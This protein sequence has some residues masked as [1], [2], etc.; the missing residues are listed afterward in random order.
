MIYYVLKP[1]IYFIVKIF[2][3]PSIKGLKNIPNSG[4]IILAGNHTNYLDCILLIAISRR[5]IHFLAKKELF[6]WY[7][8]WFFKGMGVIPVDRNK[9]DKKCKQEALNILNNDKVLGIFP[10]GTIN[11][12]KESFILPLKYGTVNFSKLTKASIVPFAIT[13]KYN[14]INGKLKIE[15]GKSFI[16]T[17]DL[18]ESNNKLSEKIIEL[19]KANR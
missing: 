14:I 6:K 7:T 3:R 17:E 5:K 10:E 1:I 19:I 15:F 13:G 18:E 8:K 9:K 12:K 11:R 16:S 4:K 2:F